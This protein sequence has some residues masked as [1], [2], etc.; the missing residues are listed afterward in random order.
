MQNTDL[1]LLVAP[2]ANIPP[3]VGLA[4]SGAAAGRMVRRVGGVRGR[5]V[6]EVEGRG[7]RRCA[8]EWS[9]PKAGGGATEEKGGG[10]RVSDGG[11]QHLNVGGAVAGKVKKVHNKLPASAAEM[12][13]SM[14]T[15]L[16]SETTTTFRGSMLS[17]P[18]PITGFEKPR[19]M[20][21]FYDHQTI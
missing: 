9:A 19:P 20:I 18:R 1:L 11:A 6:R 15:T 21:I 10:D 2:S 16:Q 13:G 5:E 7:S 8:G 3:L 12:E 4:P 14:L 17:G